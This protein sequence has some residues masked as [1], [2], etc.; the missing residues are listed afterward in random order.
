[1]YYLVYGFLWLISLLPFR[2]LYFIS[3]G[4]YGLIYY[5]FGYRKGVVMNNLMIAFPE[6]TDKERKIIAK[7][8]YHNLVD[9]FFESIKLITLS[10]RQFDKRC[11]ANFDEV[12]SLAASGTSIEILSGHQ[13]NWEFAA[14]IYSRKLALPFVLVYMPIS[15]KALERIFKNIRLKYGTILIDA[16][17]YRRDMLGI[18]KKQHA[19][20]LVADQSPAVPTA[21][22]WL[23]FFSKPAPF[24]YA[25]E[26]N[27]QRSNV[28]VVFV[29]FRRIKRGHFNFEATIVTH[30]PAELKKGELTKMYRDFL[31]QHIREQ[32][33]NYLWSHRRWKNQY[34][35]EY[36]KLWIDD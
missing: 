28:P 23:N 19:L 35:E 5:I 7:K 21:G 34:N 29:N 20:G 1:M 32:P 33:D 16:T 18:Y 8:F 17:N 15:N 2:V 12:N 24:L 9:Y 11:K 25:P 30:K 22:F 13:F 3:D 27:A 26:K 4:L 36:A 10:E 6:K 31:Q 14:R